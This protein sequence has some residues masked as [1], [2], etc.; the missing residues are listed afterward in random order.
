MSEQHHNLVERLL[1][2]TR[3]E[4]YTA[5]NMSRTSFWRATQ[6]LN[7]PDGKIVHD[8]LLKI[9]EYLRRDISILEKHSR[10]YGIKKNLK[11]NETL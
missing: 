7:I 3:K 4:V 11:H 8:D 2:M 10:K 5:L 9:C 1:P 6:F